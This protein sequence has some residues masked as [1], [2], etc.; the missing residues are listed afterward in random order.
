VVDEAQRVHARRLAREF[1]EHRAPISAATVGQEF[2][3]QKCIRH[4]LGDQELPRRHAAL[5]NSPAASGSGV[6]NRRSRSQ[7]W[8]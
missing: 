7:E 3:E 5:R 1:R 2:F 6:S 8:L 4:V